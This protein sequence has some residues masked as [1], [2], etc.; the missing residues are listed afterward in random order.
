MIPPREDNAT[1][2]SW[3]AEGNAVGFSRLRR[4][5]TKTESHWTGTNSWSLEHVNSREQQIYQFLDYGGFSS[6]SSTEQCRR[7]QLINGVAL[8]KITLLNYTHKHRVKL[9]PPFQKQFG[10]KST[11]VFPSIASTSTGF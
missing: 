9:K 7:N 11:M 1:G 2:L 6:T 3:R 8:S 4:N 5:H 10:C